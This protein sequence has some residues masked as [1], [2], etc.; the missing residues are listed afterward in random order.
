MKNIKSKL[1]IITL[2]L[3][4]LISNS[5]VNNVIY[6]NVPQAEGSKEV[7]KN[8]G[9]VKQEEVPPVTKVEPKG[10]D[11]SQVDAVKPEEK[12]PSASENT[13][14]TTE[15][16]Q[17]EPVDKNNSPTT[18]PPSDKDK[19]VKETP[20]E[21]E[22][23]KLQE[24]SDAAKKIVAE[25]KPNISP[26]K[27]LD[28]KTKVVSPIDEL[29]TTSKANTNGFLNMHMS[30]NLAFIPKN[31]SQV[32]QV[33]FKPG[34]QSTGP[35]KLVISGF[36]SSGLRVTDKTLA[37]GMIAS[38]SISS[39]FDSMTINFVPTFNEATDITFLFSMDFYDDPNWNVPNFIP[40]EQR[41]LN[42]L[43]K[44]GDGNTYLTGL[45]I[46]EYV[47]ASTPDQSVTSNIK[48]DYKFRD[49]NGWNSDDRDL[50][51]PDMNS[52]GTLNQLSGL[53]LYTKSTT[54]QEYNA[55]KW[56]ENK[57]SEYILAG[58]SYDNRGGRDE[59]GQPISSRFIN[60]MRIEIPLPPDV[61]FVSS[62]HDVEGGKNGI[63]ISVK[64]DD[65]SYIVF[66]CKNYI[67]PKY[68]KDN[69]YLRF[70]MT[71]DFSKVPFS[72]PDETTKGSFSL[73]Q[74]HNFSLEQ[75]LVN[76]PDRSQYNKPWKFS[77]EMYGIQVTKEFDDRSRLRLSSQVINA[78]SLRIGS[79]DKPNSQ[80][81]L[82]ATKYSKSKPIV[83]GVNGVSDNGFNLTAIQSVATGFSSGSF[84][85]NA[86]PIFN[87]DLF[88]QSTFEMDQSI[89]ITGIR[90]NSVLDSAKGGNINI[91]VITSNNREFIMNEKIESGHVINLPTCENG[92]YIKK[93]TIEN[94]DNSNFSYYLVGNILDTDINGNKLKNGTLSKITM[95]NTI[96]E[97]NSRPVTDYYNEFGR[98]RGVNKTSKYFM[99]TEL[100]AMPPRINVNETMYV[101][102]E[103]KNIT[104]MN[105]LNKTEYHEAGKEVKDLSDIQ[106]NSSLF[107]IAEPFLLYQMIRSNNTTLHL[108]GYND[109]NKPDIKISY[110]T[111]SNVKREIIL[112]R[113]DFK[114]VN[115]NLD[116]KIIFDLEDDECIKEMT[117]S[118]SNMPKESE[119]SLSL[120]SVYFDNDILP[121][122]TKIEDIAEKVKDSNSDLYGD[123][124]IRMDHTTW[125]DHTRGEVIHYTDSSTLTKGT[126]N[127]YR[128]FSYLRVSLF[129]TF[130]QIAMLNDYVG[131]NRESIFQGES[132]E[133]QFELKDHSFN[134]CFAFEIDK[135]FNYVV[136]SFKSIYG[137]NKFVE[138][139]IPNYFTDTDPNEA[140]HLGNGLLKIRFI[141][142]GSDAY[143]LFPVTHTDRGT[144]SKDHFKFSVRAKFNAD[145]SH[146]IRM[147]TKVYRSDD[148]ARD[149]LIHKKLEAVGLKEVWDN[150]I[151]SGRTK[152]ELVERDRYDEELS[153]KILDKY[154]IDGDGNTTELIYFGDFSADWDAN[155]F[156]QVTKQASTNV[157]TYLTN[158]KTGEEIRDSRLYPHEEVG[159]TQS[160]FLNSSTN[161]K[162]FIGYY[163][164]PKKGHLIKY[165][166]EKGVE[167]EY[168]SEF[169]MYL[170]DFI[171]TTVDGKEIAPDIGLIVS[172]F[173][174]DD[175]TSLIDGHNDMNG[176]ND[177]PTADSDKYKTQAE[178]KEMATRLGKSV[179]DILANCTMVKFEAK[180]IEARKVIESK[181]TLAVGHKDRG[182]TGEVQDFFSGIYRYADSE[183][184][185]IKKTY[186]PLSKFTM[187]P[188]TISG[189]IF[190]DKNTNSLMD[191]FDSNLSGIEVE[192][193]ETG[194][195]PHTGAPITPKNIAKSTTDAKG[196]FTFKVDYHGDYYLRIKEPADKKLC[197]QNQSGGYDEQKSVF[198][199]SSEPG[200]V[201]SDTI[202][203]TNDSKV[204]QN[205]GF[206]DKRTLSTKDT[207]Y[208][209][210]GETIKIPY[211][212]APSY[213]MDDENYK[214]TPTLTSAASNNEFFTSNTTD[215]KI[216]GVKVGTGKISL[217]IPNDPVNGSEPANLKKEITIIVEPESVA[218]V[219]VPTKANVYAIQ[220]NDKNTIIA[221]NLT[222]YNY[223]VDPVNAYLKRVDLTNTGLQKN[224]K[225]IKGKADNTT[226]ADNEISLSVKSTDNN[227]AFSQMKKTDLYNVE[228]TKEGVSLGVLGAFNTN[229]FGQF[230]FD[231]IY[232]PNIVETQLLDNKYVMSY[233]FTKVTP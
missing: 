87:D 68:N 110:T 38:T 218:S 121:S 154:D 145:T 1:V 35:R 150:P 232:N 213:L 45:K 67:P 9:P 219:S 79:A 163:H 25:G 83:L 172:Y 111:L 207:F 224:L 128:M 33:N 84:K 66:E 60:N 220:G 64:K 81:E 206:I 149:N 195:D 12:D 210:V 189:D 17:K 143:N 104:F 119:F 103:Y 179:K 7:V 27:I 22:K 177:P 204:H 201:V 146:P 196:S 91:K 151:G 217:E 55:N 183:G 86:V 134:P 114:L 212:I 216:T 159:F 215:F 62:Q 113:D 144:W 229:T 115:G 52:D 30:N 20:E 10:D 72:H 61:T 157:S 24:A 118:I 205:A 71:L 120:D 137:G 139:W 188:Y 13:S 225:L 23:K 226:Y 187:I 133:L 42:N 101:N 169:D 88:G 41:Y 18:T 14:E 140:S 160:M 29:N 178:V 221:P 49:S 53:A 158:L 222:V 231:G 21:K 200:Y 102:R 90:P 125:T 167:G 174:S 51:T 80:P 98:Y 131:M 112:K 135:N 32:V 76:V 75:G 99:I 208:V 105:V 185:K 92:E 202:T 85:I 193:W 44:P 186:T 173:I 211:Q 97:Y 170:T 230:T 77:G 16:S 164:I 96:D 184:V 136:G 59:D 197:I 165:A 28:E 31:G 228:D 100:E 181:T 43:S 171:K 126:S 198:K 47:D 58:I 107:N 162:D 15:P 156:Q 108:K 74:I 129:E 48:V 182:V 138:E 93:L 148:W 152:I 69:P 127:D 78:S 130:S 37:G 155:V 34:R 209:S 166:D 117:Y 199:A 124:Q 26:K 109:S 191:P 2:A 95:G 6:G 46:L 8:T 192:L 227:N 180:T 123:K 82:Y 65:P 176:L 36:S 5:G 39:D 40:S 57:E 132:A 175:P 190:T 106:F 161:G 54:F 147:I 194:N 233:Y 50:H 122:G 73:N 19:E 89:R 141:G 223:G 168:P 4:L 11:T 94:V 203:L 70:T 153:Y 56:A 3:L 63:K 214:I 142:S 116:K